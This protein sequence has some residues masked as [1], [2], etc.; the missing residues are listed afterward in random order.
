MAPLAFSD[1][2]MWRRKWRKRE[3]VEVGSRKRRPEAERDNRS[4]DEGMRSDEMTRGRNRVHV[5]QK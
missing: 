3:K 4:S 1:Q 5:E 2:T